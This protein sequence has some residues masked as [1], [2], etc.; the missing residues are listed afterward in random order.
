MKNTVLGLKLERNF[1]LTVMSSHDCPN[2]D[3][4]DEDFHLFM[5][6]NEN[7]LVFHGCKT[8]N[9]THMDL[10]L[11]FLTPTHKTVW[12]INETLNTTLV[13]MNLGSFSAFEGKIIFIENQ[14]ASE[15]SNEFHRKC[16]DPG[17]FGKYYCNQSDP[18]SEF[19]IESKLES[20]PELES[21][22][23]T[24]STPKPE[25]EFKPEPEPETTPKPAIE[26]KPEPK[27]EIESK[28]KPKDSPNETD[29]PGKV[30][31]SVPLTIIVFLFALL[32]YVSTKKLKNSPLTDFK[33]FNCVPF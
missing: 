31:L 8:L 5:Y 17:F 18:E 33:D 14:Y 3:L 24:T 26:L 12:N 11:L 6:G 25:P 4:I 30:F 9:E 32:F 7:I 1:S 10:G 28:L 13:Q 19:Q 22:D 20:S 27:S 2:Y 21:K 29:L 15:I 23:K 16:E